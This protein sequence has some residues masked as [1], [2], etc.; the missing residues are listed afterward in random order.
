MAASLIRLYILIGLLGGVV[1]ERTAARYDPGGMERVAHNRD[2]PVVS[3]MIAAPTL[4][5]GEWV[6]VWG[7]NTGVLRWCRVTDT[8]QPW[9]KARHI[10][11]GRIELGYDEAIS[12]CGIEHINDPPRMCPVL[13]FKLEE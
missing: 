11:T 4:E 1:M 7:K 10:R 5:I 12:L 9:D 3:C 6:Y 8:S 13:V 2:L